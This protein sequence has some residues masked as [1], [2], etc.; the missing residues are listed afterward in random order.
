MAAPSKR[1]IGGGSRIK[2]RLLQLQGCAYRIDRIGECRMNPVAGH[3]RDG[4]AV[5]FDRGSRY[6]V[7]GGQRDA[8]ALRHFRPQARAAL[9]VGEEKGRDCRG[10]GHGRVRRA[11]VSL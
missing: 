3:L 5:G 4:T 10:V 11:T 6:G 2:E 9:D 7:M 1:D 8:H